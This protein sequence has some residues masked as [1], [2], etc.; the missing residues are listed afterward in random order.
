MFIRFV[1]ADAHPS[2][3]GELGMFAARER[4]DFRKQPGRV[5]R[6]HEE[7]F[8]WFSPRGGGGLIYPG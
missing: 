6:A 2:G 4:I 8:Y 1:C 5:Q 7:A 3:V